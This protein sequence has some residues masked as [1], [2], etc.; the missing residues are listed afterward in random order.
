MSSI[1]VARDLCKTFDWR[2]PWGRQRR[3]RAVA[4]VDLTIERGECLA[5]VGESG[6]GKT[7]LGRCLL[8]LIE[9][10]S[11]ELELDNTDLMTLSSEQL[12]RHRR[13]FQMVFQDSAGSLD[14]RMRIEDLIAEPIQVHRLLPAA[15]IPLRV[16]ALLETVG[17]SSSLRR[18]YPHQ[19]SGGQRQRVGIARALATEPRLLVLDE[20]V[21]ALDVSVRAQ[22]LG[23]LAGL[24]QRLALTM[25]FIAHDLAMVEQIADRVAVMYLGRVVEIGSKEAVFRK[26]QHPYTVSLLAAVPI[27]DPT[28]RTRRIRI[29]GDVPSPLDPP[30]GCAFHPR[31]LTA[32]EDHGRVRPRCEQEAPELNSCEG[33]QEVSCHYPGEQ[34]WGE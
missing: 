26:P 21:S 19:L 4:G 32:Q 11:G 3:L 5:L 25:L 17:L 14:P 33:A 2:Q 28:R 34:K 10:D 18:R 9:P 1:L 6:S 15:E 8:R 23:L 22:I 16:S 12:R 30:S 27:P 7:T 13:R 31:C 20:P 24:R 29:R